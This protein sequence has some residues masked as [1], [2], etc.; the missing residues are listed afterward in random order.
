MEKKYCSELQLEIL[1]TSRAFD[2]LS[3]IYMASY[4]TTSLLYL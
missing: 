4:S 3:Y 1:I 2:F